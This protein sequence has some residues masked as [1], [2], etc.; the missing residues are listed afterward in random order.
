MSDAG[1]MVIFILFHAG[2]FHCFKH[3]EHCRQDP[4]KKKNLD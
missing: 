1:I 2:G 4:A 3:D